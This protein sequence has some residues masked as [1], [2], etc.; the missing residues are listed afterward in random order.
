MWIVDHSS[1]LFFFFHN[2]VKGRVKA[3]GIYNGF[4][5]KGSGLAALP[6]IFPLNCSLGRG[7]VLRFN[8]V[9]ICAVPVNIS[10]DWKRCL[11]PSRCGGCCES[12][13]IIASPLNKQ[14]H[15]WRVV[16]LFL[17]GYRTPTLIGVWKK[18]QKENHGLP[19]IS[20]F[21][22]QEKKPEKFEG[23]TVCG[24]LTFSPQLEGRNDFKKTECCI[25]MGSLS[26][27]LSRAKAADEVLMGS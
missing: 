21:N 14:T 9:L 8:S 20:I 16:P 3:S 13:C 18:K 26:Q 1:L 7:H 11:S 27:S 23:N 10:F 4:W 22:R 5:N 15:C 17:Y 25:I 2:H 19:L 6:M 24:R 12:G